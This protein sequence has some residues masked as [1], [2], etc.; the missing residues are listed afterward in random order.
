MTGAELKRARFREGVTQAER[1]R[2]LKISPS[3]LCK[4]E[5]GK[6]DAKLREFT[7]ILGAYGF[8]IVSTEPQTKPD[9]WNDYTEQA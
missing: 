1:A 2:E 6:R 3:I 8:A 5:K 9:N 4:I 7:R